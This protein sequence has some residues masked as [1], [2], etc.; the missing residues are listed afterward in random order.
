MLP[1]LMDD[2]VRVLRL[3]TA[4]RL[5]RFPRVTPT[6]AN[7]LVRIDGTE[8]EIII[9]RGAKVAEPDN[10]VRLPHPPRLHTAPRVTLDGDC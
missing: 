10:V 4:A 2:V 3:R 7:C 8:Y 9:K 6:S 1:R 5:V